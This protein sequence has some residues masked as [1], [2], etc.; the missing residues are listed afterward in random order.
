M[1]QCMKSIMNSST[2]LKLLIHFYLLKHNYEHKMVQEVFQQEYI[3]TP[4]CELTFYEIQDT[5]A[6]KKGRL[7]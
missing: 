7:W 4:Y 6:I 2:S 5:H 1:P 3:L